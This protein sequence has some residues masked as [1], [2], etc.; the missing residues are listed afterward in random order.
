MALTFGATYGWKTA[1]F[2]VPFLAS[3]A[4]FF[5]FVWYESRLPTTHALVPIEV[6]RLPNILVLVTFALITLG[7]WSVQFLAFIETWLY[8]GDESMIVVAVRTIPIGISAALISV[9]CMYV[10]F[11]CR[12]IVPD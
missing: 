8:V 6:L 2:L 11:S 9:V 4:I 10:S 1:A 7:W 3:F 5:I 12:M